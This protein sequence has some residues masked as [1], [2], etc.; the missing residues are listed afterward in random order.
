MKKLFL[1]IVLIYQQDFL[2]AQLTL[3]GNIEYT[4]FDVNSPRTE[5]KDSFQIFLYSHI[6]KNGLVTVLNRDKYHHILSH[7]T[8]QLNSRQISNLNSIFNGDKFLKNYMVHTKLGT[9]DYYA[10]SYSFLR[11]KYINSKRDSLCFIPSIMNAKFQ[12]IFDM[13]N[14]I[15]YQK[16]N[17]TVIKPFLLPEDFIF[18]TSAE[19]LRSSFLPRINFPPSIN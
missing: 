5:N 19:Y 9:G 11:I 4:S 17:I 7:Y 18:S 14:N 6:N 12:N 3:R 16:K 10:G 8:Y 2:L 1:L 13:L 15:Y